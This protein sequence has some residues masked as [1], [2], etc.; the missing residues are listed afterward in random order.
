MVQSLSPAPFAYDPSMTTSFST[1]SSSQKTWP[2]LEVEEEDDSVE[3]HKN[4]TGLA[5]MTG[6]FFSSRAA[7]L[8]AS[9][10]ALLDAGSISMRAVP[11]AVS[12]VYTR[13][14]A[15]NEGHLLLDP[16]NKEEL[17]ASSRHLFAWAFGAGISASGEVAATS[18]GMNVDGDDVKGEAELVWSESEGEFSRAQVCP[19]SLSFRQW[20]IQF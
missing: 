8:N 2:K 9:T 7:C 6:M 3:V 20:L 4:T 5:P 17:N 16:S 11:I 13:S 18:D 10:L 1:S 15:E 12:I 14:S 19:R